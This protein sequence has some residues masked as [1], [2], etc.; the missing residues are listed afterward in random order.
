MRREVCPSNICSKH[1]TPN[2]TKE[3]LVVEV[4]A[5]DRNGKRG[6]SGGKGKSEGFMDLHN[7]D[8]WQCSEEQQLFRVLELQ[9]C[10]V[11]S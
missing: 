2:R 4:T 8:H 9:H 3:N 10:L 6:L 7:V 1:L 5:L 11:Y